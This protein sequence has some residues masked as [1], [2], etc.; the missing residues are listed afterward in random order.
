M[1]AICPDAVGQTMNPAYRPHH[2]KWHRDRMPIF[3]WLGKL[4]YIKFIT[5][6]LTSLAVGYAAVLLLA[7]IWALARGPAAYAR[8][9]GFLA[10]PPVVALHLLVGA[11]LLFHTVTWLGLAPK[12]LVIKL[13]GRRLPDWAVI[14]GHYVMLVVASAVVAWFLGRAGGA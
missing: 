13:G 1:V 3:W 6:E 12:A 14:A 11:A 9:T 4:S 8:F 2:P 10:A 5:R 7:E